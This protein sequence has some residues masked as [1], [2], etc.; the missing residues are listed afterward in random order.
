MK[1][2]TLL[3]VLAVFSSLTLVSAGD[4]DIERFEADPYEPLEDTM[5]EIY[6]RAEDP[7]GIDRIKLYADGVLEYTEDCDDDETCRVY[8]DLY[9]TEPGYHTYKAKVY[10]SEGDTESETIEVYVRSR[11]DYYPYYPYSNPSLTASVSPSQPRVG[12]S[13]TITA[14]ASDVDGMDQIE[15]WHGGSR[16]GIQYC[17]IFTS[18]TKTFTVS[19]KYTPSTY[20]FEVRA[21][22]DRDYLR[23]TQLNV[24]VSGNACGD[25]VCS[26]GE[27][28]SSCSLDCGICS[29][30]GDGKCSS[31][32]SSSTC[33][34]D[35]G[36][37]TT[38]I[39]PTISYTCE[40]RGGECCENGGNDV[41]DGAADC[42]STCFSTCNEVDEEP[43]VGPA[44]AVVG[45]DG[46]V[47]IFGAL[48]VII[49]LL[50]VLIAKK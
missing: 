37:T 18:C 8:F 24:Y 25:G 10:D 1:A 14:T 21:Y 5:F 15:L 43:N 38:T 50:L 9:E 42:P 35:C 34:T 4:P 26:S 30:C 46:S 11:Y 41:V 3:L 40:Q 16:I 33:P 31:G 47:A 12:Q 7:D 44:G 19:P 28:C 48:V 45:V 29:Y 13:F 32:E 2:I 22:D 36:S 49:I 20:V 23:T 6:V 39:L 27:S 17:G